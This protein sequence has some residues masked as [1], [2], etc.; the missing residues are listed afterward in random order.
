[1]RDARERGLTPAGPGHPEVRRF[2]RL[3]RGSAS[4]AGTLEGLGV[5]R[6]AVDH[7]AVLEAL[8][9]CPALYRSEVLAGALVDRVLDDEVAG[10]LVSPRTFERLSGRR[11]GDGLAAIARVELAELSWLA[12]PETSRVLVLD[13]LELPGNVGSLIR[14][15][16]AVDATVVVVAGAGRLAHPLV[17]RSSVGAVFSVAVATTTPTEAL[18]WLRSH[19]FQVL[20]ADPDGTSTYREVAYARRVAVVV[21][22]ERFGLDGFWR[23]AAD[24]LVSI[25]MLGRVDSL[26]AG[27]A[28]AL[29]LFEAAHRHLAL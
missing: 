24:Q 15:A 12:V 13:H 27:H 3:R 6:A 8:F 17:L 10:F 5:I 21:G 29:V 14:T 22:S 25:P 28:G 26:N 4:A 19:G 2:L 20:A 23:R 18:E 1:M 11:G 9:A 7:G 16:S